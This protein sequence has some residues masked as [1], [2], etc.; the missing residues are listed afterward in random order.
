MTIHHL[1]SVSVYR[2]ALVHLDVDQTP[3]NLVLSDGGA[4]VGLVVTGYLTGRRP[5]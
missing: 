5:W 4:E 1:R 2:V 3:R